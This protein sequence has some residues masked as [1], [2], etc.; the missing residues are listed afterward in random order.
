MACVRV[1]SRPGRAVAF[2]VFV[3]AVLDSATTIGDFMVQ[4]PTTTGRRAGVFA[5]L[6]SAT[7]LLLAGL[8]Q[9]A[10]SADHE[11]VTAVR[12]NAYGCF[13]SVSLF[14]G[15]P[16]VRG[17][18][19][20]ATLP[21]GGGSDADMAAECRVVFGPAIIFTSGPINTS[22]QG[23]TGPTGSVT[24]TATLGPIN[25]SRQ[26][27]FTAGGLSSTCTANESGVTGSTTVTSGVLQT[28]EGNP[29]VQGD[30]TFV[31]VPTN[32]APNTTYEGQIETVGDRFR[33]VF[34]EQIVNPDGSLTVNA[35]HLILLGPTAVGDVIAGQ[36]VCGV[37][38][39]QLPTTT[40][41]ATT[42]TTE[43]TTTS[44]TEATTTTSSSTSSTSSTTM[45]TTS[46][47]TSSTSSTTM[48]TTS[49]STSSTS[50]TT[51]PTTSSSTSSTSSTTMPTTSSS[52]SSTSTT[53]GGACIPGQGGAK[54][55][56]GYGDKNHRHC[57]PPGQANKGGGQA[58]LNGQPAT[59][60][61]PLPAP[62][63]LV[64]LGALFLISL[65]VPFRRTKGDHSTKR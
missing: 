1:Q 13:A 15:P 20:E 28:S 64:G 36:V 43:A 23:T 14:G 59:S 49:S 22:T 4:P 2:R 10:A 16:G 33:A 42:S 47:S 37:T 17:P 53:V 58:P 44:T 25:T 21:P 40:T 26:E 27:V 9:R 24:S 6:L 35:Y 30:E 65:V 50:S 8:G 3:V 39:Q 51:M 32:P 46:S 52:T 48:P 38:T 5:L 55:G 61:R 7:A 11:T 57:G 29:D 31:M 56:N 63:L 41:E 12:G 19:A 18:I 60:T 62:W 54:P 34:N 45:P